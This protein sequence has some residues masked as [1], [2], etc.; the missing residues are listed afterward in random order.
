MAELGL[1]LDLDIYGPDSGATEGK[2]DDGIPEMAAVDFKRAK[3]MRE[4]MPE[5]VKAMK[6]GR[7]TPKPVGTKKR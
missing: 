4:A 6:H 3:P 1:S 5:V 2:P 7:P